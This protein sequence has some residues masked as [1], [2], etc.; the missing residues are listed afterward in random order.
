MK[1]S[2]ISAALVGLSMMATSSYAN[3]M[4]GAFVPGNGWDEENIYTLNEQLTKK[5]SF[6]TL[7]SAFSED[8]N[9]LYWQTS[10]VAQAG[11]VPMI[12]WMPMDLARP[13]E[14]ILPEITLGMWDEYIDEWSTKFV[15]WRNSYPEGARP[16][17]LLRFGHEF[18]GNWYSYGDSPEWYKA[19]YQYIFDRFESQ[20]INQYIDWVWCAN[21][22][23][24]DSVNDITQYY[25]GNQYVDWTSID[26]YNWGSNYSWTTWDSFSEVYA[27]SYNTLVSNYPDKP[28]LVA[29][30]GSAEPADLPDPAWGQNGDDSDVN[31][32]KE[33]WSEEMMTA[34]ETEFPAIRAISIFNINKELGWSVTEAGNTGLAG[35]NTGLESSYFISE[36]LPVSNSEDTAESPIVEEVVADRKKGKSETAPGKHKPAN[37]TRSSRRVVDPEE[38]VRLAQSRALPEINREQVQRVRQGFLSMTPDAKA[39]LKAMK[40][41]VLDSE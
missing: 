23:N 33:V 35:M 15:S 39:K 4:I 41:S 10:K 30:Y 22:V 1:R 32:S 7:F 25:P 16:D 37:T 19:A 27:D 14:N 20:G 8:W 17:I 26:G 38:Q 24:V 34:L 13:D 11:M 18:N 12:S 5:L 40:R 28:V 6:V 3:V 36:Y 31:E 2:L 29:E 21:N 9:N